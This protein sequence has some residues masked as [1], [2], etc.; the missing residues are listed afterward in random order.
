MGAALPTGLAPCLRR[1]EATRPLYLR[2]LSDIERIFDINAKIPNCTLDL[3]MT[4]QGLHGAQV[5]SRP[6]GDRRLRTPER[7]RAIIVVAEPNPRDPLA[8]QASIL[9]RAEMFGMVGSARE[10]IA[11][12]H[13][14]PAL[15][16]GQDACSGGFQQL[17][18]DRSSGLLLQH[19][20]TRTDL[21]STD[22]I[23]NTDF[24]NI[25]TAQLAISGKIKQCAIT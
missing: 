16:P 6:V 24:H 13:A 14:F 23:T 4:E 10:D 18:L 2:M 7:V 3:C 5:A 25:A 1:R 20:R 22:K 9:P 8:Y 21:A 17:K 11:I 12:K 19:G 15:Q